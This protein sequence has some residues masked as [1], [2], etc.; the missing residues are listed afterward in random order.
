MA[1][2]RDCSKSTPKAR[3]CAEGIQVRPWFFVNLLPTKSI[4]SGTRLY[5]LDSLTDTI[6][7]ACAI[8]SDAVSM[9]ITSE[10]RGDA[11]MHILETVYFTVIFVLRSIHELADFAR[12]TADR[13]IYMIL[14]TLACLM[15][16]I[17]YRCLYHS[18][19]QKR[20]DMD[21]LKNHI[22]LRSLGLVYVLAKY[23]CGFLV[24][25]MKLTPP[26]II[27]TTSICCYRSHTYMPMI[28]Y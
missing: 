21:L 1:F 12:T 19:I 13:Y 17:V 9:C 5:G 7:V 14:R 8:C 26:I 16:A 28:C 24:I 15:D 18:V 11:Y 25:L 27:G 6:G 4:S 20:F 22:A 23:Y 2:A 10:S 3:T